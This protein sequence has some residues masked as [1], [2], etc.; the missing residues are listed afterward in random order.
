M[1]IFY[2]AAIIHSTAAKPQ[3]WKGDWANIMKAK[4]EQNIQAGD[5]L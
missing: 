2:V 1:Y 4:K 3:I 5:G